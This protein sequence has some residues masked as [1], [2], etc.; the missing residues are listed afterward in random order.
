LKS[1]NPEIRFDSI[2]NLTNNLS[3]VFLGNS[4]VDDRDGIVST[5]CSVISN[6]FSDSEHNE[7]LTLVCNLS[8]QLFTGFDPFVTVLI[9]QFLPTLCN[10]TENYQ[11]RL[12]AIAFITGFSLVAQDVRQQIIEQYCELLTNRQS[13]GT[14]FTSGMIIECLKGLSL[15]ISLCESTVSAC[16]CYSKI[17]GVINRML[18]IKDSKVL[19]ETLNLLLLLH[20]SI[21]EVEMLI[22][23]G[24]DYKLQESHIQFIGNYG[25][26]LAQIP[27]F[28]S[29]KIDEQ[30]LSKQCALITRVFN[31]KE[32]NTS[33][34]VLNNQ[35]VKIIGYKQQTVIAAVRRVTKSHFQE[36]M[37]ANLIIHRFLGITLMT[38][39]QALGLKRKFKHTIEYHYITKKREREQAIAKKKKQKEDMIDA[40][41]ED[42]QY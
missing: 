3:A 42:C 15:M 26:K 40:L 38:Q 32:K 37:T 22:E 27:G 10:L 23:N 4:L 13:R 30:A 28:A 2:K 7:A 41:E 24:E 5:L 12:Y 1:R 18:G 19:S 9:R 25:G 33:D 31:G 29:K 39:Q 6:P 8:L 34:I 35:S 21:I 36:Q 20:E 11:F 16:N 17:M 14:I